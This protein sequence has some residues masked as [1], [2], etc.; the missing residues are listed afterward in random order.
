MGQVEMTEAVNLKHF[1]KLLFICLQ[2]YVE[3]NDKFLLQSLIECLELAALDKH[4]CVAVPALGT[5]GHNYL[6]VEVAKATIEAV[7][8]HNRQYG[9]E[10]SI[11][12]SY[13]VFAV[14]V[15]IPAK[16]F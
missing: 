6:L 5:G 3:G 11:K 14:L 8:L 4:S 13:R 1:Q 7:T 10:T 16:Q 9:E 15:Q 2:S 12:K